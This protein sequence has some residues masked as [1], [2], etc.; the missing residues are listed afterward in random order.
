MLS[1]DFWHKHYIH[2]RKGI[3][4]F[5]FLSFLSLSYVNAQ[6]SKETNLPHYDER[7]I[8]YGFLMG[9][10]RS[11]FNLGYSNKFVGEQMDSLLSILTPARLGFD[12]GFIVNLRLAEFFDF[13]MTPK[14]G[15]Y[16]FMAEYNFTNG[17]RINQLVEST[18][19]ETPL[20]FKYKSR[21]WS[22]TR[23]YVIAGVMPGIQASGNKKDKE[24]RKLLTGDFNL[25]GEIGFGFDIY[26]PLFKFSPEIRF[27]RGLINMLQDDN[28]GY[29]DGIGSLKTNVFSIYLLFE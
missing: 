4:F 14:V 19:V 3:I 10:H 1:A 26:F 15:F 13:R 24:E 7:W 2:W 18:V 16:E 5:F 23:V 12:L 27:S 28:F 11:T 8:H 9:V 17:D 6:K 21:R 20:L 25:S 22:N 29:S